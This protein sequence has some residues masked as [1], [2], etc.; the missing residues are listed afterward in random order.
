MVGYLIKKEIDTMQDGN[1]LSRR[2]CGYYFREGSRCGKGCI[3]RVRGY[4]LIDMIIVR[5]NP[6]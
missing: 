6:T 1:Q 2:A 5:Q 4:A 3:D